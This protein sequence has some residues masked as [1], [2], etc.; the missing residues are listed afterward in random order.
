L[1]IRTVS[2][3]QNAAKATPVTARVES[4]MVMED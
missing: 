2:H 3:T 1:T 4:R